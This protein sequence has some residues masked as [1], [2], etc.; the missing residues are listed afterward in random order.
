MA[1]AHRA[2]MR[3]LPEYWNWVRRKNKGRKL[4]WTAL[5]VLRCNLI[6]GIAVIHETDAVRDAAEASINTAFARAATSYTSFTSLDI[7]SDASNAADSA[8]DAVCA[9]VGSVVD[10]VDAVDRAAHF[11]AVV[12]RQVTLDMKLSDGVEIAQTPLWTSEMSYNEDWQEL[13]SQI[14]SSPDAADWAFWVNWYD[15]ALNG[16]LYR[17]E[18]EALL[19]AIALIDGEDW[20]KGPSHVAGLINDLRFDHAIAAS[21]NAERIVLDEA[22]KRFDAEPV[23]NLSASALGFAISKLKGALAVIDRNATGNDPFGGLSVE[24]DMLRAAI[25]APAP[26]PATLHD[27]CLR[28]T[29]RVNRKVEQGDVPSPQQDADIED[30]LQQIDETA[31]DLLA[32]PEVEAM[33]THRA[34][35]RLD[36]ASKEEVAILPEAAKGLRTATS[37]PL[38]DE[39]VE[40]AQIVVD[41]AASEADRRNALYRFGSR[42]LRIYGTLRKLGRGVNAVVG[43]LAEMSKSIGVIVKNSAAVYLAIEFVLRLMAL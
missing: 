19:T 38:G 37:E 40:D 14:L 41:E 20:E 26:H 3:V 22:T 11:H 42:L 9:V 6:A 18:N 43:G 17:P 31:L 12:W 32:D 29:R 30:L 1:I 7:T 5:Q 8:A 4:D 10:S 36:K 2:A 34:Q 27:T 16:T 24:R 33:V 35:M 21:P 25:D 15:E 39:L 28:I 23:S 13:K